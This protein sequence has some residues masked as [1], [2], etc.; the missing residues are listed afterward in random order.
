VNDAESGSVVGEKVVIP[1]Q[2]L[3]GVIT[4]HGRLIRDLPGRVD[5]LDIARRVE[6]LIDSSWRRGKDGSAPTAQ[7][8][9]VGQ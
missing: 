8:T 4:P 7:G 2:R 6:T 1:H 5:A 3:V 9:A